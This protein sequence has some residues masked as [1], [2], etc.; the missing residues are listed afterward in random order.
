MFDYW[1]QSVLLDILN[2]TRAQNRN[3]HLFIDSYSNFCLHLSS[4]PDM[5]VDILGFLNIFKYKKSAQV[6]NFDLISYVM[7]IF[8]SSPGPAKLWP[9]TT[10]ESLLFCHSLPSLLRFRFSG[11]MPERER[12]RITAF[13]LTGANIPS[14]SVDAFQEA[15]T[16]FLGM[17]RDPYELFSDGI[18][19]VSLMTGLLMW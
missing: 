12:N 1:L 15:S 5:F 17:L 11:R 10:G 19:G 3:F 4:L 9:E 16:E 6:V 8:F 7:I 18:M 2:L 13:Q 14:G